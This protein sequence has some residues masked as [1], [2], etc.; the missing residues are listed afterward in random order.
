MP[1]CSRS[2][3]RTHKKKLRDRHRPVHLPLARAPASKRIDKNVCRF[4]ILLLEVRR[5]NGSMDEF[6]ASLEPCCC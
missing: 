6:S 3:N 1:I 2:S 5:C 4:T